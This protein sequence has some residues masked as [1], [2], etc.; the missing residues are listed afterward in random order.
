MF[1]EV[2]SC[3]SPTH[4]LVLQLVGWDPSPC[5]GLKKISYSHKATI[6]ST[7]P[8]RGCFQFIGHLRFLILYAG[9]SR[10]D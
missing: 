1:T 2:K 3:R 8:T 9:P 4:R 7:K 5:L 6:A 10:H